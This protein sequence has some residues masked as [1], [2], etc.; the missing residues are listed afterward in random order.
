MLYL[1]NILNVYLGTLEREEG[2][3]MVEYGLLLALIAVV[4]IV[5]ITAVGQG[6]I[7]N[8]TAAETALT[9]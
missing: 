1:L 2:Q 8:F 5:V 3:D 7:T 9:T 4:C 6:L